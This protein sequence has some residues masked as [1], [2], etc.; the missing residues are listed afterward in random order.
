MWACNPNNQ[1]QQWDVNTD[2]EIVELS[3]RWKT[4]S[5]GEAELL[6][7]AQAHA[8]SKG[9]IPTAMEATKGA[10]SAVRQLSTATQMP[11]TDDPKEPNEGCEQSSS[12]ILTKIKEAFGSKWHSSTVYITLDNDKAGCKALSSRLDKKTRNLYHFVRI[13]INE[14]NNK[15]SKGSFSCRPLAVCAAV[16]VTCDKKG[17]NQVVFGKG[18]II[19]RYFCDTH[20]GLEKIKKC[21]HAPCQVGLGCKRVGGTCNP[22][23]SCEMPEASGMFAGQN[24]RLECS[25]GIAQAGCQNCGNLGI[26]NPGCKRDFCAEFA[27]A[28][29]AILRKSVA[30]WRFELAKS[31][32]CQGPSKRKKGTREK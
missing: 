29:D 14:P 3:R 22:N 2:A 5:F 24:R 11:P 23:K 21:Y 9:A 4:T 17:C 18:L 31:K 25:M 19:G 26:H 27:D 16:R 30:D 7:E 8:T 13:W 20:E 28:A 10:K 12:S 6:G 15:P 32:A 1:N